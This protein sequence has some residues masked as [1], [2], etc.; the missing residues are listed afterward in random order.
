MKYELYQGSCLDVVP[1]LPKSQCIFADPFDNLGLKYNG[2][3]DKMPDPEYVRFLCDCLCTFSQNAPIVW[4][5]FY[6]KW[7]ISFG[8]MAAQF[9]RLYPDWEC[10]PNVQVFTF[11][12]HNHHDLGN[13]HRP[14]W[15]FKH[16]D[17]PIYPD[18]IRIPSW[19]QRNGDKRADSRGR[20]P[21]DVFDF[22]YPNEDADAI[23][24]L[25]EQLRLKQGGRCIPDLS[26]EE[27]VDIIRQYCPQGL[28]DVFDFPRVT[29]N[30]KQRCDWHPTQLHEDMVERCI[31]L[32]TKEGESVIDPFGGTGTT[33]RVCKKI[34]RP[35]ALVEL[36]DEY[37]N[38]IAEANN[39]LE[40]P[41][42]SNS[43]LT[44]WSAA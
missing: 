33:M 26:T 23:V 44:H 14:L 13:N 35:C 27:I 19:R 11:G 2:F 37:C 9:L 24:A 12:Q 8:E 43:E 41:V 4:F 1:T 42:H 38:K 31:K 32:S 36:T 20:V 3:K 39:L 34:G 10:D 18:Q 30:S 17:A 16:K 28:P 29:G 5:S 40:H 6:A 22:Q 7:T 25:A 21:G 15:R